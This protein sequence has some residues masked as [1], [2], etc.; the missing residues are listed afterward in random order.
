MIETKYIFK[1]LLKPDFKSIE[2]AFADPKE[3]P[4]ISPQAH[5]LKSRRWDS[6]RD[7]E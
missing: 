4:L 1:P 3:A 6:N 7:V 2:K 5:T